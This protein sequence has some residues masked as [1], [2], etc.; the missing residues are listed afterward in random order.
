MKHIQWLI[1]IINFND[2]IPP[3]YQIHFISG[4][5]LG[6]HSIFPLS[7]QHLIAP[8]NYPPQTLLLD[9]HPL[10]IKALQNEKWESLYKEK[11]EYFNPIQTQVFHVAYHTNKPILMG[12]PAGSGKTVV[13]K[14]V[15]LDH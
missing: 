6:S 4:F 12:A 5:W 1:K 8:E 9:L 13:A 11:F 7:F 10:P 14:L 2:E 15:L 3:Q